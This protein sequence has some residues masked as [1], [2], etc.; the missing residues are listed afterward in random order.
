[1]CIGAGTK[2]P[3]N[4]QLARH[5]IGPIACDHIECFAFAGLVIFVVPIDSAV[6]PIIAGPL[7]ATKLHN[8]RRNDLPQIDPVTNADA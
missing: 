1:M 2:F 7:R 3:I 6:W 5:L 4:A 8:V